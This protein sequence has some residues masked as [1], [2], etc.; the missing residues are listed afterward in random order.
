MIFNWEAVPL[1]R[2]LLPFVMGI[3]LFTNFDPQIKLSSTHLTATLTCCLIALLFLRSYKL[4]YRY[5]WFFG[6]I[7]AFLLIIM[8][9]VR[10][11][12]STE[13]LKK[14]HFSHFLQDSTYVLMQIEAPIEEKDKTF[15]AEVKVLELNHKNQTHKVRGKALVYFQK[16]EMVKTLKYGDMV[17]TNSSFRRLEGAKNP[18]AFDY[19]AYMQ[20]LQVYHQS[21]VRSEQ[22][23]KT[24][25]NNAHPFYQKIYQARAYF[26]QMITDKVGTSSEIGVASAILL[27]YKA[28]LNDEVRSTYANTGAMH[29]LAVSGLHVGIIFILINRLLFFL[30]KIHKRGRILKFILVLSG[31]WIYAF[32]TGLPPSVSRATAM[33]SIF[34]IGELFNRKAFSFNA[35]AASAIVLLCYNPYM[36]KMLGFQLSYAAVAS[37][38]WLQRP[39]YRLFTTNNLLL[40]YI[41]KISSVSIAA[42]LGT[43]PISV[44]Y[45]HQFPSYFWLSNLVVIPAAGFILMIGVALFLL[46]SMPYIGS[47]L[48]DFLGLI[49][50]GLINSVYTSLQWIQILPYSVIEGLVITDLQ[51][52]FLYGGM[53]G[54]VFFLVFNHFKYLQ[55]TLTILLLMSSTYAWQQFLL[56]KQKQMVVYHIPKDSAIEFVNSNESHLIG[57]E[58]L[59]KEKENDKFQYNIAPNQLMSSIEAIQH[60]TLSSIDTRQINESN[61]R[62]EPPFIQF[63]DKKILLLDDKTPI[64]SNLEE[65]VQV[66]Y[67]ILTQN[68][69]LNLPKALSWL[70]TEKV[71]FDVSNS[72]KKTNRWKSAC[73]LHG[74]NCHDV[75]EKGA[76]VANF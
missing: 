45:F 66:D 63:H 4:K 28:N 40:D 19:A 21:Y 51:F 12:Q 36:I 53:V 52:W 58:A 56:V 47:F 57:N 17:L 72:Y 14:D 49:L 59:L 33:F 74:L 2:N 75:R 26:L 15:K 62:F 9:F 39:I 43:V 34:A 32:I 24:G 7:A 64:P 54:L 61:I 67:L 1:L 65:K 8:G 18:H 73:E 20:N 31:I 42:Q 69:R 76:F 11:E 44:Y 30:E 41:W 3:L 5:R 13:I 48:G 38:M 68:A 46:G 50:K 29:I 10:T 37:I 70:E 16:S 23:Q 55:W 6:M 71:I 35:L 25:R 22:W 60:L 27:G